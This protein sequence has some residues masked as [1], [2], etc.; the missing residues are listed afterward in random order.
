MREQVRPGHAASDRP[1]RRGRLHDLLAEP[2]RLLEA[3]RL[4]ELQPGGDEVEDRRDILA[5]KPQWPAAV[6]AAIARVENDACSRR[7]FG[8]ARLAPAPARA[9]RR[10][11][12]GLLVRCC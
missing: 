5:E 10:Y 2:T 9:D 11:L 3:R 8:H 6:G 1:G 4:H 7:V 12:L